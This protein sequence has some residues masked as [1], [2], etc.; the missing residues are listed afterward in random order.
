MSVRVVIHLNIVAIKMN[1]HRIAKRNPRP[2]LL[3]IRPNRRRRPKRLLRRHHPRPHILLGHNNRVRPVNFISAHV[4]V[5]PVRIQQKP[6]RPF[7]QLVQFLLHD[8]IRH[9]L[10]MIDQQITLRPRQ[11]QNIVQILRRRDLNQRH[12]AAQPNQLRL[13]LGV[14]RLPHLKRSSAPAAEQRKKSHHQAQR[15]FHEK[16]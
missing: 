13:R 1:R 5:V 8:R 15:N 6:H 10:R 14:I 4:I 7:A 2:S 16:S 9:R 12:V 3:R 11:H